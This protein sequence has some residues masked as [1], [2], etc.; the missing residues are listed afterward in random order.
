MDGDALQACS[1]ILIR[2]G[3]SEINFKRLECDKQFG[4]GTEEAIA[5]RKKWNMTMMDPE[6]HK[7]GAYQCEA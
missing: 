6:L 1:Y 7:L 4:E 3:L 5:E 2:H